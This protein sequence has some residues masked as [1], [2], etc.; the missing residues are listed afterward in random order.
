MV[1][2]PVIRNWILDPEIVDTD[3]NWDPEILPNSFKGKK[4]N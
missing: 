4:S 3:P 1:L 2:V